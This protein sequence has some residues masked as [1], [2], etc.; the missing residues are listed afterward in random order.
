MRFLKKLR[1]LPAAS[2]FYILGRIS[3]QRWIPLRYSDCYKPDTEAG[4][5]A[6]KQ[7]NLNVHMLWVNGELSKLERLSL[8]SFVKN[9]F[10][11]NLWTY[12]SQINSPEGV[13]VRDAR[14]IVSEDKVFY[15]KSGSLAPFSDLFRYKVL[16]EEPGLWCDADVICL[17]SSD[18][19]GFYASEPFLVSERLSVAG[20]LKVNGNVIYA[21]DKENQEMLKLALSISETLDPSKISGLD[22]GPKL[23]TVLFQSF[24]H[25]RLRVMPPNFANGIDPWNC[26]DTLLKPNGEVPKGAV[27]IHCFNEIWRQKGLDKNGAYPKDSIMWKLEQKY[28]G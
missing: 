1:L 21:P 8:S 3:T 2:V 16:L 14:D 10:S 20:S 18:Q 17:T 19:F 13:R 28:L 4:P 24:P 6:E 22:L 26:P 25:L 27:F 9:G 7:V 23:M 12:N 5:F 11:V 15:S